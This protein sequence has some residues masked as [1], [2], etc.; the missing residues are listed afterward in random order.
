MLTIN[1]IS[2]NYGKIIANNNI[3]LVVPGGK[4]IGLLG[5]NGAGKSTLIN[6]C[7]GLLK[8]DSGKVII[9]NTLLTKTN[10]QIRNTFGIVSPNVNFNNLLTVKEILKLI[11]TLR[12]IT[13]SI[14]SISEKYRLSDFINKKIG[15]LSTGM[16]RRV[17]IACS[18]LHNPKL[19]LL[20]EPTTGLDP[21]MRKHIWQ[22]LNNIKNL[23]VAVLITTHYFEE[24][25][26]LCDDVNFLINGKISRAI[27]V[28]KNISSIEQLEK[29]YMSVALGSQ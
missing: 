11:A 5:P 10:L 29:E 24:A 1:N 13:V 7:S 16:L 27:N 15:N 20:D 25:F 28:D 2:K 18:M 6:I 12:G 4:I 26:T 8:Q 17:A 21:E 19:L 22:I 9:N 3:S 23:G 14:N